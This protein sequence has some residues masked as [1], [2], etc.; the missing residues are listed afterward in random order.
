MA[1]TALARSD[2][3]TAVDLFSGAG[4]MSLG[5]EQAG[6]DVLTALDHDPVHLATYSYN[7][8]STRA[9]C[10]DVQSVSG[11]DIHGA[12]VEGWSRVH[13]DES[14]DGELDCVFGGPSCQGF[15]LIGH[16]DPND[17][18][19]RLIFEFARL[20]RELRPRYFVLENVPGLL[21]PAYADVVATVIR[22]LR[23][24]GY[25][26]EAPKVLNSR[27]HGVPQDRRRV[28]LIGR[29]TGERPFEW[30]ASRT[31]LVAASD[32][33]RNLPDAEAFP[34]LLTSDTAVLGEE[35]LASMAS[36]ATEYAKL[37]RSDSVSDDSDL[38]APRNWDR[39]KLTA[40]GRTIHSSD[41]IERF[42]ALQPSAVDG[43]S[44]LRRLA[45]D[46]PSPTLRAGTGPDHGS[47]TSARPIH[48][49]YPRVITVR[50]AARLHSFPDWFRFHVTK[51]HGFRQVGNAV[52]PLLARSIAASIVAALDTSPEKPTNAEPF[53]REELL[54]L[55]LVE[56]A[57]RMGFDRA[58]LPAD[59]RTTNSPAAA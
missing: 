25:S 1:A 15:S 2:R 16:R 37:L 48:Y 29:R 38:S 45:G 17:P 23:R 11:D 19:N 49:A 52:P 24:A 34:S 7:F 50:E 8:P 3:P 47:F 27:F 20:V 10:A 55:S 36:R 54:G 14:W 30:P 42:L 32:A 33:L 31:T 28:F 22:R 6:F 39:S 43:V 57:D 51:W 40:S 56:A 9:L 58:L 44:R 53:G 21:S 13:P 46:E 5:F 12:A 18:R 26:V 35:D 4:G 59:V 41:V